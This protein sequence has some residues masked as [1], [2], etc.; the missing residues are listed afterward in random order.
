VSCGQRHQFGSWQITFEQGIVSDDP[1]LAVEKSDLTQETPYPSTV[2]IKTR[3]FFP[4]FTVRA[5]Q[6][7][8]IAADNP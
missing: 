4:R 5:R 8:A 6:P 7:S 2:L 3:R 1:A